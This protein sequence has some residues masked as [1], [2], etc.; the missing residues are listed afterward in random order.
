M[1]LYNNNSLGVVPSNYI[2]PE[3]KYSH[4]EEQEIEL[5][6]KLEF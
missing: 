1:N 6:E 4:E 5:K 2:L 3:G